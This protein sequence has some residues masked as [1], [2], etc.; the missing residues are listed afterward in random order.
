MHLEIGQILVLLL[1][2]LVVC[3]RHPRIREALARRGL[4]AGT[5]AAADLPNAGDRAD[6]L[7]QQYG[8]SVYRQ[9][10]RL[11]RDSDAAREATQAVFIGLLRDIELL[12]DPETALRLSY[13]AASTHCSRLLP[14]GLVSRH[15]HFDLELR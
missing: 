8:P 13:Q 7:Y 6:R 4:V 12:Q 3:W 15:E 9:C 11:L 5:P 14:A 2:A 1:A 10:L